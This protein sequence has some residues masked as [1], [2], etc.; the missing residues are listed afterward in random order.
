V[1]TS[2]TVILKGRGISFSK[3]PPWYQKNFK[4]LQCP[5]SNHL[6]IGTVYYHENLS[7]TIQ[8]FLTTCTTIQKQMWLTAQSYSDDVGNDQNRIQIIHN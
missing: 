7:Q 8:N 6:P 1:H 4:K 3:W 2:E 5:K